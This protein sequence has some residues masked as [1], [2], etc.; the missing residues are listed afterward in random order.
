MN[1][2]TCTE[3]FRLTVSEYEWSLILLLEHC[4]PGGEKGHYN[5]VLRMENHPVNAGQSYSSKC[6]EVH[7]HL[8]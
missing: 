1:Q 8:H 6:L 4:D 7:A 3:L 5:E 2:L